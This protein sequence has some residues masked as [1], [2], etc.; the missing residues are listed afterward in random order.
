MPSKVYPQA[1]IDEL[2][3]ILDITQE[4]V[5]EML[6]DDE[7]IDKGEKLF[8]LDA[9]LEKGAKKARQ[10]PRSANSTPTKRERKADTDKGFLIGLIKDTL[11]ECGEIAN[12]TIVNQERELTFELN[13][14][15]FKIVLS[16]PRS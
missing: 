1:R 10:A 13:D 8:E 7:R 11:N 5:L 4:E 9:E 16:A 12:L 6:K 2:S 15:K 3:K 14:R